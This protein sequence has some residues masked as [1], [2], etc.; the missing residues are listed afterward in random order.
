MTSTTP[1]ESSVVFS[2]SG[3]SEATS[4]PL[5][6]ETPK[7]SVSAWRETSVESNAESFAQDS[8]KPKKRR[9]KGRIIGG[10]R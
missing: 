4:S 10:L 2:S 8:E 6:L 5:A 3:A 7:S 1:S 9:R